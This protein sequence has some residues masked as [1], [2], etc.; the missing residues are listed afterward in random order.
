MHR[1]ES[2]EIVTQG[3]MGDELFIVQ[4]GECA[5]TV[6][7]AGKGGSKGLALRY[8]DPGHASWED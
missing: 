1:K 5:A 7:R 3:E 8:M 2:S 6:R 4:S